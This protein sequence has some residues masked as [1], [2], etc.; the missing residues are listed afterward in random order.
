MN[1]LFKDMD[2]LKSDLFES[3]GEMLKP[4]AEKEKKQLVKE[5][6]AKQHQAHLDYVRGGH[7][8]SR[9]FWTGD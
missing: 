5:A 8:T 6:K 1:K 4:M 2:K 9:G 3:L 7:M